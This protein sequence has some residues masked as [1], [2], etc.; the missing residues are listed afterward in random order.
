MIFLKVVIRFSI[1]FVVPL[2]AA[3]PACAALVVFSAAD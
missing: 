1:Y 3:G 2:L